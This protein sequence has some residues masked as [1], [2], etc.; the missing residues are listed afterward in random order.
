MMRIYIVLNLVLAVLP[1]RLALAQQA[2]LPAPPGRPLLRLEA[3]GPTSY[4]ATLMF[5]P[6]GKTLY[7][8]GF[9][10]TVRV[11]I[12]NDRG[13]FTLSREA[14]RVPIG[15]GQYGAI[16]A[17]AVSSDGNWLAVGGAGT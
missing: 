12:L 3:G 11:W 5:S 16:N 1:A 7:E 6:D 9:D 8:A 14:Y 10:K 2:D 13:E 4:V 15:A 17:I